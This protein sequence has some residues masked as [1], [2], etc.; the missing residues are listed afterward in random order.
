MKIL[1]PRKTN[2]S[3]HIMEHLGIQLV[4]SVFKRENFSRKLN[5]V[6]L[7]KFTQPSQAEPDSAFYKNHIAIV[8]AICF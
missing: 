6:F 7:H 3:L 5:I 1:I 4:L 8:L 2:N